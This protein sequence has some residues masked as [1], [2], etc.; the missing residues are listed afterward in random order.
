[1]ARAELSAATRRC[2][3]PTRRRRRGGSRTC[4][5]STRTCS[6]FQ[7]SARRRRAAEGLLEIDVSGL[8]WSAREGSRSSAPRGRS[9]SAARPTHELLGTLVGADDK[10]TA[11][12]AALLANG[13]L[14]R[15][16]K[17]VELERPLL[18]ADP[19]RSTDG[20]L[21][22]R[23][24]VVAEE[25][26]RF[27]LIEE[28]ASRDAR[29]RRLLERRRRA[30]RRAEREARVRLAPEP[31]AG[32]VALR[33][34]PRARRPRRRARLGRGRLRLVEGEDP[35]PERPDRP[36][37]DLARHGRVFRGRDAAPR[38]RHLPA[39]P[40]AQHDVRL[41]I[42]GRAARGRERRLARDDP[43]RAGRPGDERV[44][45]E[46]QLDPLAERAR[47]LDPGSRDPRER[48]RCTH[49]ATISQV[50]R[51]QLFYAM[52]RGLTRG[53]AERL[54]VRGFFQDVL[55]RIELDP[56]REALAEKLEARIPR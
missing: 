48:V 44:P 5:A 27:T 40:R 37:R 1:M 20:A 10:F 51:D 35:D 15:V 33:D 53:D 21:F 14:V 28:Y 29:A 42:Q 6:R 46:P 18:R 30:V 8:A 47:G 32:D 7:R 16:P 17:G 9:S 39:A 2:R 25:G 52:S 23:L 13:L 43:R 31:L 49:G 26:R 50:D 22:W 19:T 11:H 24:L 3:C 55:D 12:N 38:L 56:V 36:R 34:A 41:R 4:A 54:I 45:G